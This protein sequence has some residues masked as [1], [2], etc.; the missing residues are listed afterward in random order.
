MSPAGGSTSPDRAHYSYAHYAE[1]EVAEGFD[2][3][4]FSGPIGRFLLDEQTQHACATRSRPLAG[5]VILDVGTGTGRAAIGLAAGGAHVIG[6]DASA[7]MLRVARARAA[8]SALAVRLG[9]GRRACA[10]A[11]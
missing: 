1:R 10:A 4:R 7:E 9:A 11:R 8:E 6:L 3:L 2:A 5:R